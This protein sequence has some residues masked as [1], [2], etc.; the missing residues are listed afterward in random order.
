LA[1]APPE[2]EMNDV[3]SLCLARRQLWVSKALQQFPASKE[4]AN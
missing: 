4:E 1:L 2:N 3:V